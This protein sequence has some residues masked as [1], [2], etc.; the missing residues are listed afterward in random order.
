MKS[1]GGLAMRRV[2]SILSLLLVASLP[3]VAEE[4]ALKDGTKIVGRM[5]AVTSDKVEVETSYGKLQLK[6]SDIVT[7]NFPENAPSKAPEATAVKTDAPKIDESLQ[8]ARY[9]NRTGKFSLTIPQEWVIDSDLRRS[10]GTLTVLSSRDKMRFLMVAQE[11]YPGSLESYKE[12]TVLAGRRTLSNYEELA[13][14]DV[15]IDGKGALFLFYRGTSQKSS[16]PMA[17]LSA[18]VPSGNTYTK[19][20][21]WCVEPLFHDMQP[22]FEKM[23]MSYRSA[24]SITAAGSSSRP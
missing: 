11:E 2:F 17:F 10:A 4:I 20:T 22:T 18:I 9:V 23:L 13:Q 7:I 14:S 6:R 12:L 21:V 19:I 5:S 3:T 1:I 15:T 16:I 8:G 24:G